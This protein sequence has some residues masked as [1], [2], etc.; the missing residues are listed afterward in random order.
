MIRVLLKVTIS[1]ATVTKMCRRAA[2]RY[3][4]VRQQFETQ[5]AQSSETKPLDETGFRVQGKWSWLH[6]MSP[7]NSTG[8]RTHEQRGSRFESLQGRVMHDHWPS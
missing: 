4:P 8:Y 6:V 7:D 1:P 2:Q 5:V 3:R